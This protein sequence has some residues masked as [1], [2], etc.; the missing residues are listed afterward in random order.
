MNYI[1]GMI[2]RFL[3]V[4]IIL[5]LIALCV[6]TFCYKEIY[7]SIGVDTVNTPVVEYGSA[8]YDVD[9]LI[10]DVDG[11]ITSVKKDIETNEVGIQELILVVSKGN[12]SREIPV[13][14]EIKD[15]V[16]PELVIK[17]NTVIISQGDNFDFLS[18]I[19]SVYD[20]VDGNLQ[21]IP[22]DEV[23]DDS[24]NYYTIYSDF[25]HNVVGEY[26]VNIKAVDKNGNESYDNYMIIVNKRTI[27]ENV[28]NIAYSLLGSAYAYGGMG[29]TAFDCSGFVQYLY[30][31]VGI[32]IS[33]S[34]STQMY[35]GV[36]VNY[37][38]ILPGDILN[39]GYSDGT[40]THSALYVGNGKMIHA[41][42]PSMGV[43]LSDVSFWNSTSGTEIIGVRRIN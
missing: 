37:D 24:R 17:D 5:I 11:K 41:A 40:S 29:P 13:S 33:R 32:S 43:I 21:Y 12:I 7:E 27:G 18:N 36:A 3:F 28:V 20:N 39:W 23:L 6:Y 14:V 34:S 15:S 4:F 1:V 16:S 31:K 38:D 35:D 19:D 30:K 26:T 8:N 25:N 2:R 10:N 42:N 9:K 22:S